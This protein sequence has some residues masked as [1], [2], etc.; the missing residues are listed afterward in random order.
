[1][2]NSIPAEVLNS[3]ADRFWVL[4]ILMVPT[5]SAPGVALAAAMKSPSVLNS[6][7]APVART[8]SKNP[9][10]AIGS[11]SLTGS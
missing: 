7:L 4:P 1:M 8:K 2:V 10:L 9:R 11:K 3:S 5:F 6:E